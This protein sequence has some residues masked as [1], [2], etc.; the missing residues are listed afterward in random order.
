MMTDES[1]TAGILYVLREHFD[2]VRANDLTL[3]EQVLEIAPRHSGQLA[4]LGVGDF[5]K[6][7]EIQGQ[8]DFDASCSVRGRCRQSGG[9]LFREFEGDSLHH[10]II[11]SLRVESEGRLWAGAA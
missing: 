3:C 6:T 7:V 5:A 1:A 2:R 11:P 9:N 10:S 4:S 8:L